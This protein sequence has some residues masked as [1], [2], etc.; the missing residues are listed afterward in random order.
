MA[1]LDMHNSPRCQHV[2]YSGKPCKAPARRGRNYCIFH[3]AAHLDSGGCVL[4]IVEDQHSYQLA[5][6]RIMRALADDA[7]D[8][9][10]ATS[11]LYGL[12]LAGWKLGEFCDERRDIEDPDAALARKMQAHFL[13][14]H[15][16]VKLPVPTE[17]ELADI[18]SEIRVEQPAEPRDDIAI[19]PNSTPAPTD[20]ADASSPL[21][22]CHPDA[23]SDPERS[24]GEGQAEGP[25]HLP[26]EQRI[27]PSSDSRTPQDDIG[28]GPRLYKEG[29]AGCLT[30]TD[31]GRVGTPNF[32]PP[33]PTDPLQGP[34]LAEILLD[35][36]K[37]I[38]SEDANS[39]GSH[40][41]KPDASGASSSPEVP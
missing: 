41:P 28:K 5:A 31:V 35:R 33:I 38:E 26:S 34:S 37:I 40:I 18:I 2:H 36:L 30:L 23:G 21:N 4:P 16:K 8:P 12:Q 15:M 25:M 10:K 27:D 6:I 32:G 14:R 11:L 22:D 7:I 29:G 39:P 9:R 1:A 24:E 13:A 19:F 17:Q 3:Q 20:A